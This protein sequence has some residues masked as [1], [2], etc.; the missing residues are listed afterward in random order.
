MIHG[1]H[2]WVWRLGKRSKR[3]K[4]READA[5][6][7]GDLFNVSLR[8]LRPTFDTWVIAM[9]HQTREDETTPSPNPR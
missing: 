6:R 3:L 7:R 9:A 8:G 1:H 4:L 2:P 5:W